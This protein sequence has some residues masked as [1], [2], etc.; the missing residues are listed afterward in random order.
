VTPTLRPA[1]AT[2]P[3]QRSASLL[4]RRVECETLD[5]L[6]AD[7]AGGTSRVLLLRGGAGSGKSALLA[8]LATRIQGWR[9]TSALGVES[10]M[11]LAHSGLHQLCSPLLNHLDE[12]PPPQRD[13]LRIVFGLSDGPAPDRFLVGLATVSLIAQAA[14][15]RPLACIV[16]DAQWLDRASA[17]TLAFVARRLLA[18]RVALVSAMRPGPGDDVFAGLPVLPVRQ[19]GEADS[20]ALL[21]RT[22]TVPLDPAV[23]DQIVAESH[24]NPLA[25]LELPRTWDALRLAGGFGLPDGR[26]VTGLIEEG[27]LDRYL[28]LPEETRL[29]VLTAAAEPRGDPVLLRRAATTLG[30]DLAAITP[31]AD[32]GLVQVRGRV[33]FVHPLVRSAVYGAA[34][35]QDR[36]RVHRALAEA[37]D[38]VTDP[39]RR[40]W[41]RARG[42]SGPDEDIAADLERSAGRAQARGGLAA[43]AAFLTQAAELTP[44]PPLRQRRRLDAAFAHLDAGSLATAQDLLDVAR[45][46][47]TDELQQA[48]GDLLRARLAF[49]SRWAREAAPLLLAA[50]RRLEPLDPALARATYLDAFS[51]DQFAARF[52]DGFDVAA[53]AR[54]AP[55]P[56]DADTDGGDLLLEAFAALTGDYAAAVPVGRHA[57]A[58]LRRERTAPATK[59]DLGWLR[60]GTVLALELWDDDAAAVLSERHVRTA[61]RTGALSELPFV[62]SSR[63]TVLVLRGE[64][65]AA[66]ALQDETRWVQEA[67]MIDAPYGGMVL[68]AWRGREAEAAALIEHHAGQA[69]ARGEG[70]GVATAEYARAVLAQALGRVDEALTAAR[71]ACADDRELVAHNWGLVEL[72]EAAARTGERDLAEDALRRLSAKTRAAGTDWALGIEAR[73]RALLAD[74]ETAENAFHEAVERLGRSQVRGE[75]ARTHLLYGEWLGRR[76]RRTEAREELDA[77]HRMFTGM[78]ILGFAERA[79]RR[80]QAAGAPTTA[81]A[82]H[83]RPD[84][85]AQEESIAR[86]AADGLSNAEIGGQLFLSARTVE[87]H[88]RKVFSKLGIGSRRELRSVLPQTAGGSA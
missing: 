54:A 82:L 58:E 2:L 27:Y 15:E 23:R 43:A 57:L 26:P 29:L 71:D 47:G 7:V 69:R 33:E 46:E 62:L 22:L 88:L 20:R 48:R 6:A 8:H 38:G 72:V 80:L 50:A 5:Q 16:D 60:H 13:A 77:A 19:L 24:G 3:S 14:E 31:A 85:T 73:S 49:V 74:G 44:G 28:R 65:A 52:N 25:V 37:T 12:I 17:Q 55:R 83:G 87:W 63:T 68:A 30:V 41:H 61:R 56:P 1:Y 34:P 67:G 79:R 75:L 39:D 66:A 59:S 78:G 45:R 40:A 76:R 64:L 9:V 11:E 21:Q 32:D 51:A 53:L 42:A 35:G 4:G 86:L 70:I 84:L 81:P 18:E 36:R 10:E